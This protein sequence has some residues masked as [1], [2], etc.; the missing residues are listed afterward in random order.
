MPNLLAQTRRCET[1]RESSV[2]SRDK[3]CV[4]KSMEYYISI[5]TIYRYIELD[6]F[7][8]D[9]VVFRS[10]RSGLRSLQKKKR[11]KKRRKKREN[12]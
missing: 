9:I 11:K 12:T 2:R 1:S 8:A 7:V 4:Q 6:E 5:T 3:R 10:I